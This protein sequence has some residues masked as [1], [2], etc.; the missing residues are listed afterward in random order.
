MKENPCITCSAPTKRK[1]GLCPNCYFNDHP[2]ETKI[3]STERSAIEEIGGKCVDCGESRIFVL[4]LIFHPERAGGT[5]SGSKAES[6]FRGIQA[7]GDPSQ[8]CVR[9]LNC[10]SRFQSSPGR[11]PTLTDE[12][13]RTRPR[14]YSAS[15][16]KRRA[17]K[18]VA[19]FG[20]KCSHCDGPATRVCY[21]GEPGMGPRAQDWHRSR[22]RLLHDEDYRQD[23]APFCAFHGPVP[24]FM[25]AK[26]REVPAPLSWGWEDENN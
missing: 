2:F 1:D 10:Q 17:E 4:R 21:I 16:R 26:R 24:Y 6:H 18:L 15:Y 12:E 19:I 3:V 9:C 5:V 25:R 13:R 20:G 11:T 23:F 8:F 14:E 22:A 7:S